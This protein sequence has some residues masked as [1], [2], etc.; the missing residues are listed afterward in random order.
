MQDDFRGVNNSFLD[1]EQKVKAIYVAEKEFCRLHTKL[2]NRAAGP[3]KG[4]FT[5][6]SDM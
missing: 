5:I 3:H 1:Q 2:F 4:R 6:N